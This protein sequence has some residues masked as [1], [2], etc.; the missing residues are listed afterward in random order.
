MFP[1]FPDFGISKVFI[2]DLLARLY[3]DQGFRLATTRFGKR[4]P[5]SKIAH[6]EMDFKIPLGDFGGSAER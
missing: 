3:R 1:H 6:L 5:I 4:Q 2:T